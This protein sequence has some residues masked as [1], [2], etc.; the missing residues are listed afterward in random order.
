[1]NLWIIA[2]IFG[3][4]FS[5]AANTGMKHLSTSIKNNDTALVGQYISIIFFALVISA[6]IARRQDTEIVPALSAQA[7]TILCATGIIW[8]GAI[9]CLFKAFKKVN[10]GVWLIVANTAV[11]F[12]YFANVYIF[13]GAEKL[14]LPQIILAIIYFIIIAQ[15]LWAW[16][17]E[18]KGKHTINRHILYAL[19]TALWWT[20]YF[21]ANTRFVKTDTLTPIQSVLATETSVALVAWVFYL[22]SHR[23]KLQDIKQ[24]YNTWHIATLIVIG[25][26]IVGWTFFFY[27]GYQDNPANI[28][29]F[30]RLLAIVVAT[31]FG[32]VFLKDTLTRKQSLLMIAAFVILILFLFIEKILP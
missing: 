6:G 17:S 2:A 32:R 25:L 29:N 15:F 7:Y 1:M 18:G 9:R 8:F 20:V 24:S 12:M 11:F 10:G 22:I 26:G 14:P 4:I 13:G 27:Y 28:I 30:I 31:I 16:S 5:G 3:A 19:G 21:V 23:G